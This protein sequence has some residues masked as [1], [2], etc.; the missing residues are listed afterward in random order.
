[1]PKERKK[2]RLCIVMNNA[3]IFKESEL[4]TFIKK[5]NKVHSDPNASDYA[6]RYRN[7][8]IFLDTKE[9]LKL[10][11]EEYENLQHYVD[12]Y[13]ARVN[14]AKEGMK[15]LIGFENLSKYIDL[16]NKMYH[17]VIGISEHAK[18]RILEEIVNTK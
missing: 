5:E 8:I 10:L 1:M 7:K 16:Y 17:P 3:K 13:E 4:P 9:G 14:D 6:K 15:K 2:E 18:N 11:A 12:T